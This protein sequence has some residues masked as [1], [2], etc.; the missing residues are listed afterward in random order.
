MLCRVRISIT[1]SSSV[2]MGGSG[3][4]ALGTEPLTRT[5]VLL[6]MIE[7]NLSSFSSAPVNKR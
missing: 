4:S 2:S 3:A 6:S 1:T 5:F 7:S